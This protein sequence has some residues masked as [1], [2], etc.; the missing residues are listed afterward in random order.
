MKV[1]ESLEQHRVLWDVFDE[2][3]FFD[4]SLTLSAR[5]SFILPSLELISATSREMK[6]VSMNYHSKCKFTRE[7]HE[8]QKANDFQQHA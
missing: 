6:A 3:K 7:F 1:T 4:S 5:Y 8:T 2:E